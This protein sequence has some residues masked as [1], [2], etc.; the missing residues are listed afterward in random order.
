[1]HFAKDISLTSEQQSQLMKSVQHQNSEKLR[2]SV[3]FEGLTPPPKELLKDHLEKDIDF[4]V[5]S[6]DKDEDFS[7]IKT[8]EIPDGHLLTILGDSCLLYYLSL[9]KLLSEFLHQ[10]HIDDEQTSLYL[11][12]LLDETI[13]NAIEHGNLDLS[14]VKD[15]FIEGSED[16]EDYLDIVQDRLMDPRWGKKKVIL[17]LRL[18]ENMLTCTIEDEGMGFDWEKVLESSEAIHH[19]RG[20]M[21]LKQ[22]AEDV[23]FEN[24]GRR[25]SFTIKLQQE[26]PSE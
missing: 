13:K 20:I 3:V 7:K 26:E 22:I 11:R 24:E 5:L 21:L 6:S 14:V 9:P 1:M 19:G 18:I 16:F 23:H 25:H 17:Q 12:L 8:I 10:H 15:G 2:C 4:Y